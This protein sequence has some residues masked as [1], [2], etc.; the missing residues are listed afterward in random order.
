MKN[1]HILNGKPDRPASASGPLAPLD[2]QALTA[3]LAVGETVYLQVPLSQAHLFALA[4]AA[5]MAGADRDCTEAMRLHLQDFILWCARHGG[6]G[7][8]TRK[9][10]ALAQAMLRQQPVKTE[11]H[12]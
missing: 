3:E 7:P 1:I 4:A 11:L 9:L 6:F 2:E 5:Q 10:L 12:G 8:E